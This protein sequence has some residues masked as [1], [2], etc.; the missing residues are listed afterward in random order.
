[1]CVYKVVLGTNGLAKW[2]IKHAKQ[3][4]MKF[5]IVQ[6]N[7]HEVKSHRITLLLEVGIIREV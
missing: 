3:K 6:M 7:C 5:Q 1:M 4:L 2:S